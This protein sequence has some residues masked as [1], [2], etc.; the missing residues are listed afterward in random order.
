M[1]L[2]LKYYIENY[3]LMTAHVAEELCKKFPESMK[4]P[5][6]RDSIVYGKLRKMSCMGILASLEQSRNVELDMKLGAY[7]APGALPAQ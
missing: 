1:S 7:M 4:D 2:S 6:W 3:P 5:A